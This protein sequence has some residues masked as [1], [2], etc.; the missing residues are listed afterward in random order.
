MNKGKEVFS[1]EFG[2]YHVQANDEIGINADI[3]E[4]LQK[5]LEYMLEQRS[6][7]TVVC[8]TVSL[9]EDADKNNFGKIV[10]ESLNALRKTQKNRGVLTQGGWVRETAP[11]S[12]KEQDHSHLV[13]MADGQRVQNGFGIAA[14]LNKLVTS[15]LGVP[16]E[17]IFVHCDIPEAEKYDRQDQRSKKSLSAITIRQNEPGAEEQKANALNWISYRAKLNTKAVGKRSFG[18]S[19]LPAAENNTGKEEGK[20]KK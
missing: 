16:D 8:L 19:R 10:G 9:P 20:G 2:G 7:V 14:Q 13:I 4:G 12:D 15:R 5:R 1:T 11:E 18:F 17:S 3:Q 6:K